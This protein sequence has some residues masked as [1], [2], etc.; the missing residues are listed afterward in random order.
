M[1]NQHLL[2]AEISRKD[3]KEAKS[4]KDVML[5]ISETSHLN[6]RL[7]LRSF[8]YAPRLSFATGQAG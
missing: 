1:K 7:I 8:A 6:K 2:M 5:I 4:A 3:R